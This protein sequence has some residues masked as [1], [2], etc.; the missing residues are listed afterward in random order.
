MA[1]TLNQYEQLSESEINT[2]SID[3]LCST[4][5]ALG[6]DRV[7]WQHGLNK[8]VEDYCKSKN[9]KI[10]RFISINPPSKLGQQYLIVM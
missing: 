9:Y 1:T 2:L 5:K 6:Q 7:I 10:S 8:E 4:A 3:K